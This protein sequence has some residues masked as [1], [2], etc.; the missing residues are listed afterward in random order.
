MNKALKDKIKATSIHL[1]ISFALAVICYFFIKQM[2]PFPLLRATGVLSIFIMMMVIDLVIGPLLTFIVYKVPK[3]TLKMDLAVIAILQAGALCYGMY[4]MYQGRPAWVTYVIDRF[5]LVRANEMVENPNLS[6]KP[7]PLGI[8]YHYAEFTITPENRFEMFMNESQGAGPQNRPEFYR[9]L[10]KARV[11]LLRNSKPL[12]E[13]EKYNQSDRVKSTLKKYP[14]A[15][16]Y[17]P[18]KGSAEDMTVLMNTTSNNVAVVAII[19]LR[20]W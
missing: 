5:E 14:E 9:P 4:S 13:L 1:L 20:P 19:D 2:Y 17:L 6:I 15:D 16:S 12:I 11:L 8:S 10:S 3:K 18:L 7:K